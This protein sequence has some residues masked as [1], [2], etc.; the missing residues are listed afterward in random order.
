M[1]GVKGL[2]RAS[3]ALVVLGALDLGL[4]GLEQVSGTGVEVLAMLPSPADSALYLLIG[5]AGLY[6]L[7]FGYRVY[8]D[9]DSGEPSSS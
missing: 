5:L 8:S 4:R 6:Q 1:D 3:L 2:D 9:L 7:Y